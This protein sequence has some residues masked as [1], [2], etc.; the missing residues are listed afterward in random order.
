MEAEDDFQYILT[1]N[2]DKIEGEERRHDI[3]LDIDG[4]KRA[5]FTKSQQF[6]GTRY[7]ELS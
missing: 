3:E 1:L 7:Q 4:V 2:R 5:T 6:L